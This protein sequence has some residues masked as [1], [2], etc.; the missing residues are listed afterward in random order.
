MYIAKAQNFALYLF[1]FSLNFEAWDPFDTN[2][3]LSLA[4]LAGFIYL[5]TLIPDFKLFLRLN[6]IS[7]LLIPLALFFF[8]LTIV[9]AYNVNTV[10]SSFFNSGILFNIFF[11]WLLINHERKEYMVLEK[12]ML[13]FA[14]GSI[15]TTVLFIADIGVVYEQ[16]RLNMFN[17]NQNYIGIRICTSVI[18]L[19][20]MIF[21]N[22]LKLGQIR[23]ILLLP[24]PFM[25]FLMAETGSRVAFMAFILAFMLG[26]VL[27]KTNG[28]LKKTM[29]IA[30]GIVIL[31]V[32]F[33]LLLQTDVLRNRLLQSTEGAD[34]AGRDVI[35][36]SIIP[37]IVENPIFGVGETGYDYFAQVTFGKLWG[38]HNVFLEVLSDTGIIG[39][40][41]YLYFLFQIFKYAYSSYKT[42]KWILPVLLLIPIF[43]MLLSSQILTKK[44]GWIIFAYIVS[45]SSIKYFRQKLINSY[46]KND[47]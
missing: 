47:K 38:A 30:S 23:Y 9:G 7:N 8:L 2:G 1:F 20:T 10:S 43:G 11:F 41:I 13:F 34:L 6:N 39:L 37:L 31:A 45:S 4:K 19:L 33:V 16:G 25:L 44:I 12:G 36:Q 46:S 27:F 42:K 14:L 35:W 24:I 40:L 15:I 22:N 18:V 5:I 29:L 28:V 17:E 32:A 26:V 3:L 21:Q